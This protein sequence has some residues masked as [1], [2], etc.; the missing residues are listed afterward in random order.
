MFDKN[1]IEIGDCLLYRYKPGDIIGHIID[2]F[3][4]GKRY[5][6]ASCYIG[7]NQVIEAHLKTGVAIHTL[8][9]EEKKLID[10]YRLPN[11]LNQ[12][13][14]IY[15]VSYLK[16]KIGSDYDLK[17][18]PSAFIRSTLLS[19]LTNLGMF[20]PLFNNP[21]KY[22]CSELYATSIFDCFGIKLHPKIHPMSMTPSDLSRPKCI[23]KKIS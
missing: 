8:T 4:I 10:I 15:L 6:H 7:N 14:K 1:K 12:H 11:K 16:T 9:E 22:F 13:Q 3:T 19:R 21:K 5:I 18:F 20:K 23:L 2:F 17:A